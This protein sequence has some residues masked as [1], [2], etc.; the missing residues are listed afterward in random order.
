MTSRGQLGNDVEDNLI[1]L[2]WRCHRT[3]HS[4]KIGSR[5]AD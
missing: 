5:A 1:T 2:C 3:L 4:K